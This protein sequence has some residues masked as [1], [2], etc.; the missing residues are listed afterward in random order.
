MILHE[1]ISDF[2]QV[3][4]NKITNKQKLSK[5]VNL[6]E[7]GL[8]E[9]RNFFAKLVT[10]SIYCKKIFIIIFSKLTADIN[11]EYFQISK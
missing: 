1:N 3:F 9:G 2:H 8:D 6:K 11:L 5:K 4:S 10:P 7:N